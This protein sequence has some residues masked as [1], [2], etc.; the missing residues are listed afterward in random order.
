MLRIEANDNSSKLWGE[1]CDRSPECIKVLFEHKR[2]LV[3]ALYLPFKKQFMR[4]FSFRQTF[5]KV[6]LGEVNAACGQAEVP[7]PHH[8][9]GV[10]PIIATNKFLK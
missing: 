6:A 7:K 8:P 4:G 10:T 3:V 1:Y 9:P 2:G 5:T